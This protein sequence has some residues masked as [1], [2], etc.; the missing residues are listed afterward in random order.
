M[1]L[2]QTQTIFVGNFARIQP[3]SWSKRT[4]MIQVEKIEYRFNGWIKLSGPRV[5]QSDRA[6]LSNIARCELQYG[7]YYVPA[8]RV[9]RV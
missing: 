8:D 5:R 1:P 4:V 9:E 3:R 6:K 2:M 7:Y